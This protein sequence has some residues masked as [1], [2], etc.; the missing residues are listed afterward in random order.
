MSER[1]VLPQRRHT[2]TFTER[3]WNQ[4]WHISVGFFPDGSPG[5]VFISAAKLPGSELDAA[6]RDCGV[7]LSLGLQH[8]VPLD[9]AAGAVTRNAN[10][11]PS[12]IA[13]AVLDRIN[14]GLLL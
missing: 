7:L 10:G 12:S 1:R 4:D 6:C 14:K 11:A 9:V 8:G 2:V 3:F 5:E 13:G